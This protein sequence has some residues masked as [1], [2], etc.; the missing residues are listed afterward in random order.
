MRG[1]IACGET[2]KP[3]HVKTRFTDL[4]GESFLRRT[5][6]RDALALH[7]ACCGEPSVNLL[8]SG[9]LGGGTGSLLGRTSAEML[10]FE[11]F[12]LL[13]AHIYSAPAY[14]DSFKYKPDSARKETGL[15][16]LTSL[17]TV[18]G[19]DWL[20][21]CFE[22]EV[23][24][25]ITCLQSIS[26]HGYHHLMMVRWSIAVLLILLLMPDSRCGVEQH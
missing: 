9:L 3:M 24:A 25:L 10:R 13:T 22:T 2:L 4:Q 17:H 8:H 15:Q 1:G 20:D 19:R 14:L 26:V 12:E 6:R 5:E 11:L 23:A 21:F 7:P 16:A 18:L